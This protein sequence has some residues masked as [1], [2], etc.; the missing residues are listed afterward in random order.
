MPSKGRQALKGSGRNSVTLNVQC[1]GDGEALPY[2]QKL[3]AFSK[4]LIEAGESSI[5]VVV[6][7]IACEVAMD[8]A[9]NK[10]YVIRKLEYLEQAVE[11][12]LPGKNLGN[13]KTRRLYFS[14][15]NDPIEKEPFWGEFKK[16]VKRRNGVSHRGEMVGE[17]DAKASLD[18]ATRLVEHLDRTLARLSNELL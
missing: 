9:L 4:S 16:S 15:S 17:A 1:C 6:A 3:L 5:A 12:L 13:D 10:L 18:A 14:L 2:P 11:D 8:R 7:H